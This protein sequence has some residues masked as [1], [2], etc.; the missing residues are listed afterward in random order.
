MTADSNIQGE[1]IHLSIRSMILEQGLHM[2]IIVYHYRMEQLR[3]IES[4]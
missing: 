1:L 4:L 2:S 3:R